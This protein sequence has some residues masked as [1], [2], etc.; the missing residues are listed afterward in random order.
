MK[1]GPLLASMQRKLTA[2]TLV[3]DLLVLTADAEHSTC[4]F[5]RSI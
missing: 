1:G 5:S 3:N 4:A 2:H